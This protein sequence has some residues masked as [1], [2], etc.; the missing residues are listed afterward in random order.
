MKWRSLKRSRRIDTAPRRHALR[1]PRDHADVAPR[2][3]KKKCEIA[4][5]SDHVRGP[6][7]PHMTGPAR[8]MEIRCGTVRSGLEQT[9]ERTGASTP[10][11]MQIRESTVQSIERVENDRFVG[12]HERHVTQMRQQLEVWRAVRLRSGREWSGDSSMRLLH[13]L[14]SSPPSRSSPESQSSCF[15]LGS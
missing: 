14:R 8:V 4:I 13:G 2:W 1:R 9:L 6:D 15:S 11:S 5:R 7:P 3:L 10:K 12:M